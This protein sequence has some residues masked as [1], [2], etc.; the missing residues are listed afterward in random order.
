MNLYGLFYAKRGIRAS[1]EQGG[2]LGNKGCWL[3]GSMKGG[4]G[5]GGGIGRGGSLGLRG[6]GSSLRASLSG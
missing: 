2:H 6:A 5:W 1:G 4:R 3:V